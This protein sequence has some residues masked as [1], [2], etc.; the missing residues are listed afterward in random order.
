MP[1]TLTLT[2]EVHELKTRTLEVHEHETLTLE[3]HEAF[4]T[5]TDAGGARGIDLHRRS[6]RW[7]QAHPCRWPRQGCPRICKRGTLA[8]TVW[9][10]RDSSLVSEQQETAKTE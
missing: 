3:V 9:S 6:T 8:N 1:F 4:D 2:L 10:E 7:E 5:D